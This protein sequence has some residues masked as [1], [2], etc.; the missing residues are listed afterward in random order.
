M[1]R[2][3]LSPETFGYTLVHVK[4]DSGCFNAVIHLPVT[5]PD[6]NRKHL[7]VTEECIS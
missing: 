7:N 4:S 3:R 6:V 2:Y 5:V 1:F